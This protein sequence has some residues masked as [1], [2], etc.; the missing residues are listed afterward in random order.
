VRYSLSGIICRGALIGQLKTYYL[1]PLL[2]HH[3]LFQ[4]LLALSPTTKSIQV[5]FLF[6][7]QK[8]QVIKISA[9]TGLASATALVVGETPNNGIINGGKNNATI[10]PSGN[11]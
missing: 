1:K 5:L 8:P 6:L 11:L 10:P 3:A 7:S 9:Y 4:P 2:N